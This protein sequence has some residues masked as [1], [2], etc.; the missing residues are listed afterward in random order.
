MVL[1]FALTVLAKYNLTVP[2]HDPKI[3][4]PALIHKITHLRKSVTAVGVA[5]R[6]NRLLNGC[7]DSLTI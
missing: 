4:L 2:A 3:P 6:G 1:N 7:G 5:S